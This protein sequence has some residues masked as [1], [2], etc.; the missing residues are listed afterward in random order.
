[1]LIASDKQLLF[2]NYICTCKY[3]WYFYSFFSCV[4]QLILKGKKRTIYKYLKYKNKYF[5]LEISIYKYKYKYSKK[6]FKYSTN[7]NTHVFDPNPSMYTL[8][9]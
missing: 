3:Q 7:T 8:C 9:S 2:T 1:M 6:V 4:V 5:L